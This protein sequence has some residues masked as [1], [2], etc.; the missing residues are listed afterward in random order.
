L[1]LTDPAGIEAL[2]AS[3]PALDVLVNNAGAALPGGKDEW[4]PDVFEEALRINVA[5]AFRL[6]G[7]CRA[8]LKASR[9]AGGGAIVNLASMSSYFGI[10]MVPGY[11]AA[12]AAVV[13]STKTLA[14]AWAA[15]GIR[16]NAVAPGHVSTNMTAPME[17]IPSITKPILAR[18]PM[19]RWGTPAE[20][21]GAILFLASPA[22][23]FITGQTLPVDGGYSIT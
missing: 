17:S 22:A 5:G 1:Q 21:A 3:L 18:T 9:L 20:I 19:Q 15:D 8:K 7:A 12:K 14:A 4:Q 23:A 16:V 11:G 6:A 2:A 13:Q 10:P